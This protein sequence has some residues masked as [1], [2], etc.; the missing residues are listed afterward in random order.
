MTAAR[1][2]APGYRGTGREVAAAAARGAPGGRAV[3]PPAVAAPAGEDDR[4]ARAF[5]RRPAGAVRGCGG[6]A[7]NTFGT[8]LAVLPAGSSSRPPGDAPGTGGRRVRR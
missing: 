8:A 1:T 5:R 2:A 6:H 7:L 4:R 3:M